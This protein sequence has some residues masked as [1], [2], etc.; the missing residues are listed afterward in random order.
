MGGSI[1]QVSVDSLNPIQQREL[2]SSITRE[3][4][5]VSGIQFLDGFSA[6]SFR[7]APERSNPRGSQS[8]IDLRCTNQSVIGPRIRGVEHGFP[9][10]V[11]GSRIATLRDP[12]LSIYSQSTSNFLNINAVTS[13]S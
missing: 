12:K 6:K 13:L 11:L 8:G 2:T 5:I 10:Q 7:N 3:T 9:S 4:G 1:R